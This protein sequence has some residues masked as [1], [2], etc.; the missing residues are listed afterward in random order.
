M[1]YISSLLLCV[2]SM[3]CSL[4]LCTH[5]RAQQQKQPSSPVDATNFDVEEETSINVSSM[6]FIIRAL[7]LDTSHSC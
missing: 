2:M 6:S 1:G 5:T 3:A 4:T 7:F